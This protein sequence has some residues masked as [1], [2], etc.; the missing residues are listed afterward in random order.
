MTFE[1]QFTRDLLDLIC[2][3]R[4]L[5]NRIQPKAKGCSDAVW[6]RTVCRLWK[7]DDY[8]WFTCMAQSGINALQ[9]AARRS[10]VVKINPAERALNRPAVEVSTEPS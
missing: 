8:D 4:F 10:A 6:A 1:A 3:S 7:L 2:C 5:Q 9:Q